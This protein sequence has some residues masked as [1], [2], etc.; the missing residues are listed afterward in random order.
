MTFPVFNQAVPDNGYI[1][2]YVDAISDD[3]QYALTI[4]AMLGN[5]F[6]PYYAASRKRKPS[7]PLNYC[8]LNAVL[9][10]KKR[11]RWAM[12]ERS[13]AALT[14][15][16]YQLNIGPSQVEWD[17]NKLV[18][19]VDEI[20]VPLPSKLKGKITIHPSS[21]VTQTEQL[22]KNGNHLWTP[23]APYSAAE[24][25]F[26]NPA[27]NWKGQAYFDSNKGSVPLEQ[28]FA[29]W[30]WSRTRLSD[31]TAILYD[32]TYW[33]GDKKTL[34]INIDQQGQVSPFDPP[35]VTILPNTGWQ[36]KRQTHSDDAKATVEQTL[37]DTPFYSRSLLN[38][39]MQQEQAMAV[40]ES[41]SLARFQSA[42]VQLLLPFRMP[43][44]RSQ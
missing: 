5:V 2:W 31:R 44:R 4:I 32:V 36:I 8:A 3:Q 14:R 10:S 29:V 26:V 28:D 19:N 37:E 16:E 1:W 33:D 23:V 22:D 18:I 21:M 6:S 11:K 25:D 43:R 24:I 30:D 40:H 27:L 12:T 20:T 39:H 41:L 38:T 15:T 35:A 42:W 34:A 13:E 9:Y 17:G 7:N